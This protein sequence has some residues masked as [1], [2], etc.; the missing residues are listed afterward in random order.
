MYF[1]DAL[2]DIPPASADNRGQIWIYPARLSGA[3]QDDSFAMISLEQDDGSFAWVTLANSTHTH[4]LSDV[5]DVTASAAEV[6]VLDGIT[7]STAELNFTD[8]VT[9]NI[10][11]QLDGKS[12]TTHNHDATYAPI[13]KGVTN[14][15]SHDH[16]GGDGAQINHTT[17]SNIGT[18]THATIDAFISDVKSTSFITQTASGVIN[19]EQALSSLSSGIV[20]VTTGTGVLSS[21]AAPTG[22]VVGD[23]D[24]QTLTNKTLTTPTIGSFTNATHNHLTAAGGGQL[25]SIITLGPLYISNLAASATAAM[26]AMFL[27]GTTVSRSTGDFYISRNGEVI[28]ITAIA[29]AN[30]T[31]GTATV[32]LTVNG[33][34][35]T[36]DG[37]ATCVL[38]A[39][40]TRRHA[41][42]V[43]T[44][45]GEDV[46]AGQR[47]GLQV[48][49]SGWGPTTVE[50]IAWI[51]VR[52]DF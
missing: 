12:A 48:T 39:T 38:D 34:A 32:E 42:L 43:A 8:G 50:L 24:S 36:F 18:N 25:S 44:G 2:A 5:T 15:D 6:N 26:E 17:L 21:V 51:I 46:T 20:K 19:S 47:V 29:N 45:D 49:T 52:Q 41:V 10:Q 14:G 1:V 3:E 16:N 33:V 22:A 30:R 28:G 27:D 31:G 40:N 23:T 9:S 37:G 35:Q 13:A 11:T 4:T 7:A